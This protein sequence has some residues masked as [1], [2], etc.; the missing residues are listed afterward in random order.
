MKPI[1]LSTIA[2]F[3]LLL[4]SVGHSAAAPAADSEA[5]I[6]ASGEIDTSFDDIGTE[7]LAVTVNGQP[8]TLADDG[9]YTVGL[10]VEPYYSVRVEGTAIHTLIQTFG[11]AELYRAACDCLAL[12]PL[13]VIA[14]KPGRIE[15]LF[16]GDTMAGRRYSEPV[17]GERVLVDRDDPLPDLRELLE[18]MR[19]YV[20]AADLASA[21]L[22]IVLSDHDLADPAPKS[23]VFYAPARLADALAEAGFDH[24]SLGNNHS[25]DYLEE[26]LASTIAAVEEAGL[27]WSGAGHDE[28]QAL[29]ASRLDIAGQP[30]SMLGYVGWK[31][32]VEPNQVAEAD[33]G[34]A[35]YGSDG[36]ITAGVT[37]EAA[38]GRLPIVQYHGSSE[39]S[40]QP[41]KNS[42]RR[43]KLAID[44]GA[45][46]V[47]SHHPHV[48][49]G[50]EVYG[51]TL[52]AYSTGNFLFDQ[53]FLETHGSFALK[54]WLENGRFIRAEIIPTRILDYRP[55][56]AVGSMR[57]A[58]LGRLVRLSAQRGT[59]ITRN[60][61][62]GVVLPS[63]GNAP[64]ALAA[65][66]PERTLLRGG[67]FENALYGSAID[68]SLKIT[69]GQAR[70]DFTGR[71]GHVLAIAAE[72]DAAQISLAPSTFFRAIPARE[73]LVSGRIKTSRPLDIRIGDQTRP[74]GNDRFEALDEAPIDIVAGGT[75][76]AAG[77]W[78]EFAFH[79]PLDTTAPPRPFRPIITLVAQGGG[80]LGEATIEL[81]DL[82][83]VAVDR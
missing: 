38:L 21:N 44:S 68:R 58:V 9:A 22:E 70:Y 60:G 6:A 76:D 28:K 75:I 26:G 5:E 43:M 55:V 37:R 57:E 27:A 82:S 79:Y 64:G 59:S 10:Q 42:E 50:L 54:V 62:H 25:Y 29:A 19:P 4:L 13:E 56:P 81:D 51:D 66:S 47:A 39:Y 78:R 67:D 72:P 20:E 69:G 36:N 16:V 71:G 7:G 3:A 11:I 49:Q 32:G 2:A 83:M 34:G 63:S 53:Y 73:V 15:L 24:V 45:A 14:R 65:D 46:L 33:K 35:A 40:D 8:A 61:G 41:S 12:P 1:A 48:P 80:R 52:I 74:K 31:G 77:E 30:L 17:W 18:P 23:I